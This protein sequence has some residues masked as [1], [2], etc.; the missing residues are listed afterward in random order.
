[1]PAEIA[2]RI[3]VICWDIYSQKRKSSAGFVNLVPWINCSC[4]E[5][6]TRKR[7]SLASGNSYRTG[8]VLLSDV[9]LCVFFVNG[10]ARPDFMY[11][12]SFWMPSWAVT[13]CAVSLWGRGTLS[14]WGRHE[15][16]CDNSGN[17]ENCF[18]T[19]TQYKLPI[20]FSISSARQFCKEYG[21]Y[22]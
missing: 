5:F 16:K 7:N 8:S 20:I 2:F 17:L 15:C 4:S 6:F 1:M 9:V 14:I 22:I 21:I 19:Q 18:L 3:S 11:P 12:V 13:F 10:K